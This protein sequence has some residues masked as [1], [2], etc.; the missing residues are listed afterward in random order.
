[1]AAPAQNLDYQVL[2]Q[3]FNPSEDNQV[4]AVS[5]PLPESFMFDSTSNYEAPFAQGLF[6]NNFLRLAA[7]AMGFKTSTQALTVQLWQ[8]IS[9]T[10]L[11]L[12]LEF[13]TETDPLTDVRQPILDLLTLT[14][15][16]ADPNT[17]LM[18]SPGPHLDPSQSQE[19]LTA[20]IDQSKSTWNA[21]A[22]TVGKATGL[23]TSAIQ[24]GTLSDPSKTTNDGSGS[25]NQN[26]PTGIAT[27]QYW[28]QNIR[29]QI[30]IQIGNYM[31]FDSVV[32]TNVQQTFQSNLDAVTGWPHHCKVAVRFKPLFMITR[33][34]LDTIFIS[35]SAGGQS[36]TSG[37]LRG[38]FL[39]NP[40]PT[41]LFS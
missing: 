21:V 36:Q 19:I 41:G 9:D 14:T 30:S 7:S 28:K 3:S 22:S 17:G 4:I 29:N 33:Q 23:N 8:G 38:L 26:K 35:P 31:F 18:K 13:Q 1:M 11:S 34:D 20:T 10:E 39:Q 32:I 6:S 16:V 40:L 27:A 24:F 12:E 15:P 25:T 2:I 37:A 5:A